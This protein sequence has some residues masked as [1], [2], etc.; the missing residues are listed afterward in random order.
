[1]NKKIIIGVICLI[2][3][4]AIVGYLKFKPNQHPEAELGNINMQIR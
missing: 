4:S 1:M 2:I 3:L